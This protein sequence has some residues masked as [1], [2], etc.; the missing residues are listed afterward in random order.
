MQHEHLQRA[1]SMIAIAASVATVEGVLY[2]SFFFWGLGSSN[3]TRSV[4]TIADH[5]STAAGHLPFLA[6][7]AVVGAFYE[8]WPTSNTPPP[9]PR[10][11]LV[12]VRI[13]KASAVFL[14]VL[15]ALSLIFE[16]LLTAAFALTLLAILGAWTVGFRV[17]ADY[18]P[19]FRRTVLG[20]VTV[21]IMLCGMAYTDGMKLLERTAPAEIIT[22]EDGLQTGITIGI[23]DRG[24]LF[25][26]K[27]S[28]KTLF[29]SHRT[30]LIVEEIEERRVTYPRR[31]AVMDWLNRIGM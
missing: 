22:T 31:T 6:I 25:L 28:N 1:A 12:V 29:V 10:A 16:S 2:D 14:A 26:L 8:P 7:G 15:F 19:V 4:L 18:D 13:A 27:P 3:S 11:V 5:L 20:L 9:S 17:L 24:S 21:S 30:S 23:Y